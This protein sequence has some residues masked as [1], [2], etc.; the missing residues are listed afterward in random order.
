MHFFNF[1]GL[2]LFLHVPEYPLHCL[3]CSRCWCG[4]SRG[5]I[6]EAWTVGFPGTQDDSWEPLGLWACG[7]MT[8]L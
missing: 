7:L 6:T 8:D 3:D 2:A 5:H 1:F 4:Q